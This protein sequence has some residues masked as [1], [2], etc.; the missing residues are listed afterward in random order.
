MMLSIVAAAEGLG[1]QRGKVPQ[2]WCHCVTIRCKD[3]LSALLILILCKGE[4]I[5]FENQEPIRE[6]TLRDVFTV[7]D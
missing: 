3:T 6:I 7:L 4:Q 1:V 5:D 2:R